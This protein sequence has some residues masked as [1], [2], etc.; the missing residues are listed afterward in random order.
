[1][2]GPVNQKVLLKAVLTWPYGP[3]RGL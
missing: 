3:I 1:L 2:Y